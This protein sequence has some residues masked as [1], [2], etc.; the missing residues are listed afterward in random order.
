MLFKL[1]TRL[2]SVSGPKN[3]A[4]MS[5][6]SWGPLPRLAQL[7]DCIPDHPRSNEKTWHEAVEYYDGLWGAY[8]RGTFPDVSRPVREKVKTGLWQQIVDWLRS[9]FPQDDP[10]FAGLDDLRP[11]MVECHAWL[12]AQ[13]L[14]AARCWF[15]PLWQS[16][17]LDLTAVTQRGLAWSLYA[18]ALSQSGAETSKLPPGTDDY[19]KLNN[20]ATLG[21]CIAVHLCVERL[22]DYAGKRFDSDRVDPEPERRGGG[23]RSHRF[24]TV[25]P[26]LKARAGILGASGWLAALDRLIEASPLTQ[27][28]YLDVI[29]QVSKE[30]DFGHLSLAGRAAKNPTA[31]GELWLSN[32]ARSIVGAVLSPPRE[33]EVA[34]Y[35]EER[36]RDLREPASRWAQRTG[37]Q[38]EEYRK[39]AAAS[40]KRKNAE[41]AYAGQYIDRAASLPRLL[42]L[43]DKD[44]GSPFLTLR[45][46]DMLLRWTLASRK[47]AFKAQWEEA[48]SMF[49]TSFPREILFLSPSAMRK[50]V[51]RAFGGDDTGEEP[52]IGPM[53][54]AY[55]AVFRLFF[56]RIWSEAAAKPSWNGAGHK[57]ERKSVETLFRELNGCSFAEE[58]PSD[59]AL[60]SA[61]A[62]SGLTFQAAKRLVSRFHKTSVELPFPPPNDAG[63]P[64]K[65]ILREMFDQAA[66]EG[67]SETEVRDIY[68]YDQ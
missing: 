51:K 4:P 47:D 11:A 2:V 35:W 22:V 31:W 30:V 61:A 9:L 36:E 53:G 6:D 52:P 59:E 27:M 58:A 45:T 62:E 10:E 15:A 23:L 37:N 64:P 68:T 42:G 57:A 67:Q 32:L 28:I 14:H 54:A 12:G 19:N 29:D 66:G 3:G 49:P 33:L 26:Y 65:G 16:C 13:N 50:R 48:R 60:E 34:R 25:Y 63:L 38:P 5:E 20:R 7:L 56:G 21:D 40:Q 18:Y 17:P 24:L 41:D 8:T 55:Y 46:L 39:L 1:L 44:R 43:S